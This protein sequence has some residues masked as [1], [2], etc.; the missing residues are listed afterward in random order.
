MNVVALE[1]WMTIAI[2]TEHLHE[3]K[4]MNKIWVEFSFC[5]LFVAFA[6]PPRE[7]NRMNFDEMNRKFR[8][9]RRQ[10]KFFHITQNKFCSAI[11]SPFP[12]CCRNNTRLNNGYSEYTQEMSN[13]FLNSN[14]NEKGFKFIFVLFVCCD[15][16]NEYLCT[17]G[18][19][20]LAKLFIPWNYGLRKLS[21]R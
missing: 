17:D 11:S 16:T 10:Q 4:K 20:V 18:E 5:I 12:L 9:R 8:T 3:W 2:A 21:S 6:T 1:D 15:A 13:L 14:S 7:N 19:N